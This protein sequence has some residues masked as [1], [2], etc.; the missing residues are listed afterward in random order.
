MSKSVI[1]ILATVMIF[2]C[3]SGEKAVEVRVPIDRKDALAEPP[4]KPTTEVKNIGDGG[5]IRFRSTKGV[6]KGTGKLNLGE[7]ADTVDLITYD[8]RADGKLDLT[9]QG[10]KLPSITYQG[11]WVQ[12]DDHS[13]SI[14]LNNEVGNTGLEVSGTLQFMDA[15]NPSV[16]KLK[17]TPKRSGVFELNFQVSE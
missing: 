2:G 5:V 3:G 4:V 16:L 9:I 11:T 17:G 6:R 13:L 1:A 7:D 15:E 8:L 12:Q 10:P 14:S